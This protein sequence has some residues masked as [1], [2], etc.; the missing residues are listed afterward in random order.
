MSDTNGCIKRSILD[1]NGF[2]KKKGNTDTNE[3]V[4]LLIHRIKDP[5]DSMKKGGRRDLSE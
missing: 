1:N 2:I 4:D 3:K 5:T